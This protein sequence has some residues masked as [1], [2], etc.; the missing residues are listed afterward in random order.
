MGENKVENLNYFI[1]NFFETYS[2]LLS[3]HTEK[4]RGS[5]DG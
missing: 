3:L 2:L 4:R 1:Q 5:S